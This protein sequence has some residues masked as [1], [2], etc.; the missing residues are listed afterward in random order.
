M[1]APIYKSI[2]SSHARRFPVLASI[3]AV[4]SD[5]A[6]EEG[7]C[8][9][10]GCTQDARYVRIWL[11]PLITRKM[12]VAPLNGVR[13]CPQHAYEL[14]MSTGLPLFDRRV[15]LL[16]YHSKVIETTS[17]GP[18]AAQAA[19]SDPDATLV[20]SYGAARRQ[21]DGAI[22]VSMENGEDRVACCFNQSL[23]WISTRPGGR[24]SQKMPTG[25]SPECDNDA[26]IRT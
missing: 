18:N 21:F 24:P 19:M 6:V 22:L 23:V 10:S 5:P 17:A 12:R 9:T 3:N 26:P 15:Q 20:G 25:H 7:K 2:K 4:K 14:S 8:Q 11:D 16:I 13:Y 1:A